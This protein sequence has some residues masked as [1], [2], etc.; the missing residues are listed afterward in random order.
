MHHA[1]RTELQLKKPAPDSKNN[2]SA[3]T[4]Q[5]NNKKGPTSDAL[6]SAN[7]HTPQ[8]P[9]TQKPAAGPKSVVSTYKGPY[10]HS[11]VQVSTYEGPYIHS[12]VQVSTYEGP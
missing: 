1:L 9:S 7:K 10:I 8:P 5:Q 3:S 2:K 11:Y 12:Y 4:P 6:K